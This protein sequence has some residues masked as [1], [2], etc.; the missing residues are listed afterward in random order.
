MS[1]RRKSL[2][3]DAVSELFLKDKK[4]YSG[5]EYNRL[6]T[7]PLAAS[8]ITKEFRSY[9]NF[10]LALRNHSSW[11]SLLAMRSEPAPVVKAS[12]D[13]TKAKTAIKKPFKPVKKVVKENDS[14]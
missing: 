6:K 4:I 2:I 8:T 9:D 5:T 13:T 10:L 3:L 11:P 12:L 7:Q 1:R 14:E